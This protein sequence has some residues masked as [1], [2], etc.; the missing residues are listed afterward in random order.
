M[1]F[2]SAPV[3]FLKMSWSS[4]YPPCS[5]YGSSLYESSSRANALLSQS[6]AGRPLTY[7]T[8][9]SRHVR[10]FQLV[11]QR[12]QTAHAAA[13]KHIQPPPD[14]VPIQRQNFSASSAGAGHSW[15]G[16]TG[17]TG[18]RRRA[19]MGAGIPAVED[20]KE[21]E[22]KEEEDEAIITTVVA[23]GSHLRTRTSPLR[24]RCRRALP[25]T[26]LAVLAIR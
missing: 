24:V 3:S 19:L 14:T 10:G 23:I 11:L 13:L 25:R 18:R 15:S 6:Q 5:L 12:N 20:G 7:T 17:S 9:S 4:P 8:L 22:G 1:P 21:K 26:S 16:E 2:G